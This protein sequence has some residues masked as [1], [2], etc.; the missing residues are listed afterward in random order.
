MGGWGGRSE[1]G[2]CSQISGMDQEFWFWNKGLCKDIILRNFVLTLE[3]ANSSLV[4][5]TYISFVMFL[6]EKA[7][8]FPLSNIFRKPHVHRNIKSTD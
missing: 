6:L 2:I 3:V 7:M 8:R 1:S 5:L 4:L